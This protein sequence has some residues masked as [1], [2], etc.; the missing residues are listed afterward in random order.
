MAKSRT[1]TCTEPSPEPNL[2]K[3]LMQWMHKMEINYLHQFPFPMMDVFRM[4]SSQTVVWWDHSCP[5]WGMWSPL[6]RLKTE[7]VCV[8]RWYESYKVRLE[9]RACQ[10]LQIW[11]FGEEIVK[12]ISKFSHFQMSS[13]QKYFFCRTENFG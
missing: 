1:E 3:M 4:N 2:R 8:F 11:P 12:I 5:V 9:W 10:P 7:T 6:I 13:R